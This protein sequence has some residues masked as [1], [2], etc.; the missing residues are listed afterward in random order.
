MLLIDEVGPEPAHAYSFLVHPLL[1]QPVVL[2]SSVGLL[3]TLFSN[4]SGDG[5][6]L[7]RL[8]SRTLSCLCSLIV[9]SQV[10]SAG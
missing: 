1:S 6:V 2:F 5:S 4:Q 3:K 7:L 8:E 9:L 10:A